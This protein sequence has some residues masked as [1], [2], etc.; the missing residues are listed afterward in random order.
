[1]AQGL[2]ILGAFALGA[3]CM[4]ML[5]PTRGNA[6]QARVRDQVLSRTRDAS[7]L[8]GSK[9]RHIS[10]V[11]RGTIH[12]AGHRIGFGSASEIGATTGL[13]G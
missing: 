3:L 2:G 5:D 7:Q 11:V 6:R 9:G 1:V 10:N 8:L 12:E 4:Y 13:T